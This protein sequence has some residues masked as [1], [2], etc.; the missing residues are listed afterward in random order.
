MYGN[1]I[2][3]FFL[4]AANWPFAASLSVVMLV[5]TLAVAVLAVR[6]VDLRRFVEP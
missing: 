6:T 1:L 4:K 5:A 3:D 2:Q